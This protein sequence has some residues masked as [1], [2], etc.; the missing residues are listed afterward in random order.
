MRLGGAVNVLRH[1]G[2]LRM[3]MWRRKGWGWL[4]TRGRGFSMCWLPQHSSIAAGLENCHHLVTT[5][6]VWQIFRIGTVRYAEGLWRMLRH[7]QVIEHC[8][9]SEDFPCVSSVWCGRWIPMLSVHAGCCTS[10]TVALG[11][12]YSY[13]R[14]V[15][16]MTS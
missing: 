4:R 16:C 13:T 12:I 7:G 3:S 14:H 2:S 5:N 10:C 15:S 8:T 9:D 6:C 11:N 1:F